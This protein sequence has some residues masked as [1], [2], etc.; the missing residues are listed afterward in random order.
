M[1]LISKLKSR[2]PES[3]RY[4]LARWRRPRSLYLLLHRRQPLSHYAGRDRGLPIDRHYIES[5]LA[6][7]AADVR[8]HTLEVKDALYTHRFGGANVT[9]ADVLDISPNNQ[10]AT[11]IGDLRHLT[12]IADNTYTCFICTQTFQYI[13]DLDAAAR[14]CHRI[15]KPGGVL[16]V[17]LPCLGKVEGLE[18]N[19]A[20]NFWRFTSH[21]A[22]YVFGKHFPPD[23]LT[24]ESHGNALTGMAF[25]VG[26]AQENLPRRSLLENDPTFPVVITV[27]A[28]KR[29][30]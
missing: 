15:L 17:T 23:A 4:R 13:D 16:L 22:A 14:E 20:G 9:R 19:V 1:S 27:R 18:T 3:W 10:D 25:W 6:R 21:S 11:V 30:L 2:L 29:V 28:V 7:H 24:V 26:M 5:F 12:S 8:G